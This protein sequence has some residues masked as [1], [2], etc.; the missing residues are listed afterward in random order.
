MMG[1]ALILAAMSLF[2]YNQMD[3]LRAEQSA[4]AV[5]EQLVDR[6][7]LS[8]ADDPIQYPALEI[9][10]ALIDPSKNKM[11]EV[12]I[13]GHTYIGYLSVP[14]LGLELPVMADWSYT[15]LKLAPCRYAGTV[16]G[17]DLVLMAHN[18]ARHF[19]GLSELAEED[20]VLFTDMEGIVTCYEV[21][22]MDI[23]APTAVEE[24][25]AGDF[26]LTLFTCTYGGQSRVRVYCNRV[27]DR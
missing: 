11:A 3:S 6:V 26:D 4:A 22:G 23:L 21:V 10:E 15:K 9:P 25:V 20:R 27:K 14:A 16:G 2:L 5:M 1:T 12:E 13:D 19:G 17:G 24:M 7:P 8:E 18:Y